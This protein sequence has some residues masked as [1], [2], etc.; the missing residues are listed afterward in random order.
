MDNMRRFA[1]KMIWVL[2]IL[3]YT[4]L[5][6]VAAEAQ[7]TPSSPIKID[8]DTDKESY[9]PAEAIPIQIRIYN[10]PFDY[11]GDVIANKAFT[12]QQF[13]LAVK[14]IDPDGLTVSLVNAMV[15]PEPGPPFRFEGKNLVP[16]EIIPAAYEQI[17]GMLDARTFY[18]FGEKYGWYTAQVQVPLETYS[19]IELDLNSNL[20]SDLADPARVAYNPLSSNLIRFQI[21]PPEPI[22]KSAINVKLDLVSVGKG[23]SPET[24]R[25]PLP[26]AQVR[27]YKESKIPA[28]FQPIGWKV[29]PAIWVS[30]DPTKSALTDSNGIAQFINVEK[31]DYL[32]L[33]Q[34]PISADNQY[35]AGSVPANDQGWVQGGIIQEELR[36]VQKSTGKKTP[37]KTTKLTGSYLLITEPEFVE[38]ESD[39][40]T[41][42]FIFEAAGS[43]QITTSIKPPPGFKADYK[44]L[45]VTVVD[46]IKAVQFNV[47]SGTNWSETD[48]DFKI[49]YNNKNY[50]LTDKIGIKLSKDLAKA[51]NKT[52]FGDTPA[53]PTFEA[54]RKV[55]DKAK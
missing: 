38:W 3:L 42:P 41:Y 39:S 50:K 29:Y 25:V 17:S 21:Q 43:W 47:S 52:I 12:S 16:V 19:R 54:G 7:E 26:D 53:P 33:V 4:L 22:V 51:K 2:P 28:D 31:G 8:L 40:E 14:I 1:A 35:V 48:V 10:D 27:L 45:D 37:G 13:H 9:G 15:A 49:T 24:R 36:I 23:V 5:I 32:I 34:Y 11:V 20:F 6:T 55:K 46:G 44:S 18:K 30:V